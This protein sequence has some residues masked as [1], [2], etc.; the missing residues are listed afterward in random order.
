MK[1]KGIHVKVLSQNVA[2]STPQL[3]TTKNTISPQYSAAQYNTNSSKSSFAARAAAL[4]SVS[5]GSLKSILIERSLNNLVEKYSTGNNPVI[6]SVKD[7]FIKELAQKISSRTKRPTIVGVAGESA[8]GKSTFMSNAISDLEKQNQ[9][10]TP[11]ASIIRGDDYYKDTK[12]QMEK[13]GGFE[14]LLKTGFSW[15]KPDAVDLDKLGNDLSR[16][17]MGN[18]VKI[19][20]YDFVTSG[21]T[22]DAQLVKPSKVIVVDSIFALN[23]KLKNA[24]DVGVY[25]NATPETIKTRWFERTASRGKVGKEA[26][27]QFADVT[28]KAK[29][30][31]IPTSNNANII[32]NGEANID[33]IKQFTADLIKA[34]G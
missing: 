13:A 29:E 19:P 8:S 14:G 10:S 9:S 16:L 15:D 18:E 28:E 26:E 12:E 30:H 7:G 25:I 34:I 22:P 3:R 6:L 2:L 24:L 11:L 32:L 4:P 33:T 17:S 21:S 1:K 27:L 5:F 20:K 23:S 31:I